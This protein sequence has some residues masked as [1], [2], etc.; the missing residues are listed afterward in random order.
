MSEMSAT[1]NGC[2]CVVLRLTICFIEKNF[3]R[4]EEPVCKII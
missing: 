3:Q 1:G 2:G 4:S